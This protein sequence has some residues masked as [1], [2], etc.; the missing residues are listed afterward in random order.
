MLELK[1][2]NVGK[3][4]P[5]TS[6]QQISLLSRQTRCS[7]TLFVYELLNHALFKRHARKEMSY[8]S[9]FSMRYHDVISSNKILNARVYS[10]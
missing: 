7:Q 2:N 5:W 3:R 1:L 8:S 9:T 10:K 6:Y 4:G